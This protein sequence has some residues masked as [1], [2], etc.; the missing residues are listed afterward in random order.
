MTIAPNMTLNTVMSRQVELRRELVRAAEAGA[1]EDEAEAEADGDRDDEPGLAGAALSDS[2]GKHHR[3]SLL[4]N[5]A[6]A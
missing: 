3:H 5:H 4:T 1:L 2:N 6:S